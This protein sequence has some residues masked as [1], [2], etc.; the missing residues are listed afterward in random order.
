M[1]TPARR[2]SA[3]PVSTCCRPTIWTTPRKKSS[4]PCKEA[5]PMA[6]DHLSAPKPLAEHR[7]LAAFAGEG[8][9]EE[10]VYPSRG[11]EGGPATSHV[12]AR[13]DLNG[14]YL[15]QDTRQSRDGSEIFAS[16]A[17]F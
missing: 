16:H 14:L 7:R 3:S 9:G 4:R 12:R 1:S 11:V 2:S 6:E 10:M 13:I 15:I 17:L 5:R 8:S